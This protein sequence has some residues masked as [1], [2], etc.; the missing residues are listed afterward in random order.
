MKQ[1]TKIAVVICLLM[2]PLL[3]CREE[4]FELVGDHDIEVIY[5]NNPSFT[6]SPPSDWV[7]DLKGEAEF[8][9]CAATTDF[10]FRIT[11]VSSKEVVLT[12]ESTAMPVIIIE[13]VEFTNPAPTNSPFSLAPGGSLDFTIVF[14]PSGGEVE[15]SIL[16][17]YRTS[18][19]DGRYLFADIRAAGP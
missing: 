7:K 14:T 5:S 12:G 17:P 19:E 4:L 13:G 6:N 1:I 3:S 8:G 11:N 15:G 9:L 2:L 10:Y 16:I 18:G